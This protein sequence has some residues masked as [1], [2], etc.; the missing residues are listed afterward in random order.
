[1]CVCICRSCKDGWLA[2]FPCAAVES[3]VVA[4]AGGEGVR[5]AGREKLVDVFAWSVVGI[6]MACAG[7][8][9]SSSTIDGIGGTSGIVGDTV[10]ADEPPLPDLFEYGTRSLLALVLPGL[11]YVVLVDLFKFDPGTDG[12]MISPFAPSPCSA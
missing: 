11:R 12:S 10:A 5:P 8:E 9:G 6:L 7:I 2:E 1:M 4:G 3:K